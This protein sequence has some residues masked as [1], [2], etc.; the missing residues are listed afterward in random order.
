MMKS[1]IDMFKAEVVV[2]PCDRR[3]LEVQQAARFLNI[4]HGPDADKWWKKRVS[5]VAAPLRA[6]GVSEEE[7]RR[8]VLAFQQAVQS[9][10]QALC[11]QSAH[12]GA[13]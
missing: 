9:E 10:L 12:G 13:A 1:Q 5:R 6:A 8:Q 11:N 7:I 2:F 4:V 3:W